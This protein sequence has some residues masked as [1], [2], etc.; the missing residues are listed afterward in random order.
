MS[1]T[2]KISSRYWDGLADEYQD[3]TRISTSDFHFGPL[4]AGDEELRLVPEDLRGM[5][6][7]EVG[8]GAAQNSIY[9]ASR[10][11][12]CVAV[13]ISHGQLAHARHFAAD[14]DADISLVC[15]D[16]DDLPF[17]D[18]GVFDFIHSVY[19]LAFS[20]EPQRAIAQ[21]SRMLKPGGTCL[22]SM[23]HPVFSAEWLEIDG[24]G[25]GTFVTDYFRPPPDQRELPDG[26]VIRSRAYPISAVA[27]WLRLA[28][29][30]TVRI[31]EPE[32]LQESEV[33][34]APY[35]SDRWLDLYPKLARIPVV[36]IYLATRD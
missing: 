17:G 24:E 15:G 33:S 14:A 10:G 19:A 29:L 27:D 18:V 36:V 8:C 7:L 31:M 34:S 13:D 9:L 23:A 21:M 32:P 11:A 6:C 20:C 2:S 5:R 28:G 3:G 26:E 25:C 12:R 1:S 16:M 35:T 30:T 4:V 22:L